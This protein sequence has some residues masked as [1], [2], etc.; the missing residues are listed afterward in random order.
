[1][2]LRSGLVYITDMPN[3]RAKN[4]VLVGA[5]VDAQLKSRVVRFAQRKGITTSDI[6]SEALRRYLENRDRDSGPVK[7]A[8]PMEIAKPA[9]PNE[10]E[11]SNGPEVWML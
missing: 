9:L 6:V 2:W 3:Q 1:L 4:K 10:D 11:S 7:L 8:A 5:F